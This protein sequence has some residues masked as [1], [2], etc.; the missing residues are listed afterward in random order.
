MIYVCKFD[1]KP[2]HVL[3]RINTILYIMRSYPAYSH[4]PTLINTCLDSMRSAGDI[5]GI[6]RSL[7]AEQFKHSTPLLPEQSETVLE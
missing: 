2:R 5:E 4:I 7:A 6:R 3:C 1:F